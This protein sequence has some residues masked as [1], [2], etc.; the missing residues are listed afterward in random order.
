MN[1]VEWV[2]IG[3]ALWFA[4]VIVVPA[5]LVISMLIVAVIWDLIENI[6][7]FINERYSNGHVDDRKNK[8]TDKET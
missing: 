5:I 8:G 4:W 2:I 7:R 1:F 6:R 3:V